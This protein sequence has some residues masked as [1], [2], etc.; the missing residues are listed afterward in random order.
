[1]DFYYHNAWR[2]DW[3]F[4]NPN[5][6]ATLIA[7][8]MIAVWSMAISWRRGFWLALALFIGLA[9]CLVQT[10]SRGGMLALVVGMAVLLAGATRPWTKARV[11]AAMATLGVFAC[12]ILHA[13]AATRYGQGVFAEDP[14]ISSR[15]V[16]WKHFPAM[17]AAVPWGWG[18]GRAGDSYTQW[19]Q[20]CDQ[21][22]NYLNLINSHF[23]WM[24]EG[25]WAF[26]VFYIWIWSA[27]LWF[28]RPIRAGRFGA[29]P[30]AMW[31]TFGVG[32]SFSHVE[33]SIWLWILP[34]TYLCLVL[35]EKVRLNQWHGDRALALGGVASIILVGTVV[36]VGLKEASLPIHGTRYSVVIGNGPKLI[37]I[38]VD[39]TVMGKMYGH[40]LRKYLAECG[41]AK[42][43]YTYIV[44]EIPSEEVPRNAQQVIVGGRLMRDPHVAI[45]LDRSEQIILIN[46]ECFPQ[47]AAWNA[48]WAVKTTVYFGEYAQSP[49][50]AS[51]SSCP[52]IKSQVIDEASDFVPSWPR[53]IWNAAGI[54][55]RPWGKGA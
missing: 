38:Y 55:K 8:L 33:D 41:E 44:T 19:F 28:C 4:G 10:Y 26:S 24:A 53:A 20:P 1:M 32:S 29:V 54:W 25:G 15:L 14:S 48:R 7:C 11:I 37:V 50:Y 45:A 31:I 16:I 12:F 9:W 13:G 18:W 6:T 17:L 49:A 5:K 47:E 52:L 27:I 23:T 34:I 42:S 46:P 3:G 30:L 2:M 36:L 51:W 22:V 39:R 35:Y 43:A 21:S 40:S